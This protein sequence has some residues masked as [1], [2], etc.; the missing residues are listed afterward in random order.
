[1]K[2]ILP[3]LLLVS[4]LITLC[5]CKKNT[6]NF[7]EPAAFY[8]LSNPIESTVFVAEIRDIV[9]YHQDF[10]EILNSYFMGP[11]KDSKDSLLSP[12]PAGCAAI[13]LI[14][15]ENTVK[16]TVNDSFASLTGIDLSI[17]STAVAMTLT[18]LTGCEAVEIRAESGQLDGLNVIRLSAENIYVVD[19][20]AEPDM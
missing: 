14:Q 10:L 13:S 15:E 2:R 19:Q 16:I 18:E 17:A 1:M 6:D 12:F 5:S 9:N 7:E 4:I 11:N 20:L 3:F 8:Y